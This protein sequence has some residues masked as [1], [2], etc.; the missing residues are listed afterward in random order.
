LLGIKYFNGD[1]NN[2]VTVLNLI[3]VDDGV[4]LNIVDNSIMDYA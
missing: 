1:R 2:F 4:G 3:D